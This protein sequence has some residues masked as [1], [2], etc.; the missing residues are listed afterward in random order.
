MKKKVLVSLM[1]LG[2][3][4][5]ATFVG[6]H[7]ILAKST[8]P[9]QI[10]VNSQSTLQDNDNETN[11]DFVETNNN[12]DVQEPNYVGSIKVNDTNEQDEAS[13]QTMLEKLAKISQT[14]AEK[15]AL[16]KVYGTVVKTSLDNENGYVVYSVEIKDT[17][18]KVFEVKVD[19][20]NGKVLIVENSDENE[21][22]EINKI[23]DTDSVEEEVNGLD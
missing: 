7:F 1:M 10:A 13:E 5:M 16:K 11:D 21:K 3:V 4:T 14:D 19:A 8:T 18:G 22:E 15:I 2:L 9:S 6:R 12:D 20:G 23:T 17:Q